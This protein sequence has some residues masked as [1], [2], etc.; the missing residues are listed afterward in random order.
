MMKI[1]GGDAMQFE[2]KDTCALYNSYA[3]GIP[4]LG[5]YSLQDD[6]GFLASTSPCCGGFK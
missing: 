5:V 4:L 2:R 1:L 6:S 3:D